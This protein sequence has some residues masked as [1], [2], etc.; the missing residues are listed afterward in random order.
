M[1]AAHTH[2]K[3]FL[4][5]FHLLQAL[6]PVLLHLRAIGHIV[7]WTTLLHIPLVNIVSQ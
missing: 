6:Y 2:G 1:D 5:T 7:V 4:R 3:K